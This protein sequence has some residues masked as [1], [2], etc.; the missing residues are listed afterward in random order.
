MS[1]GPSNTRLR[2]GDVITAVDDKPVA[3]VEDLVQEIG[4][5][6]LGG[7]FK[8]D[9]IRGSQ[10]FELVETTSPTVYLGVGVRDATGNDEGAVITKLTPGSPATAADLRRGDLITA[11]DGAPI[12]RGVDVVK[13]IGPHAAGDVVTVSVVRGGRSMEVEV[14]LAERPAPQPAG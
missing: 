5:P 9:V 3:S 13:A 14:T 1:I 6:E 4:A 10:H 2:T 8:I 12:K 7:S 11:V